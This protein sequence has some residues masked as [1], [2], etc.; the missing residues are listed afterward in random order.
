MQNNPENYRAWYESGLLNAASDPATA[1]AAYEQAL[2]IQPN[3]S[4]GQ[5]D[6]GILLFQQKKYSLAAPHLE[7]AIALGLEDAHV[8]NYL[9]VCYDQ[10]KRTAG[11]VQEYQRAIALDP[12]LGEAHLNLADAYRRLRRPQALE[13]Y[14][15]AC[16]L[17]PD[18]CKY[19]PTR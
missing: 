17:E 16:E 15:T 6:L 7:K 2:A 10:T 13:E 5:R 9:G 4:P 1:Q 11:A 8:R 18:F 3:F 19:V 12:N 14:K